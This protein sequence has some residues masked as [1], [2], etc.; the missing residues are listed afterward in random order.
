MSHHIYLFSGPNG[1]G[2]TTLLNSICGK[3]KFYTRTVNE[4]EFIRELKSVGIDWSCIFSLILKYVDPQYHLPVEI[5]LTSIIGYP[6]PA[7]FLKMLVT[8]LWSLDYRV[9]YGECQE[10]RNTRDTQRINI[11]KLDK[12]LTI[13]EL[14]IYFGTNVIRNE[15]DSDFWIKTLI[16]RL[17]VGWNIY[18]GGIRFLNE[19]E[20]IQKWANQHDYQ[21]I[22]ITILR[23][24]NDIVSANKNDAEYQF[25]NIPTTWCLLNSGSVTDLITNFA[26]IVKND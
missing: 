19:Y 3:R 25:L 13:R 2:K 16:A 24:L 11:P 23:N 20:I 14:L 21:L 6:E 18:V 8:A 9:V 4:D 17:E 7:D 5:N 26:K 22:H 12:S 10:Y 1:A 15:L